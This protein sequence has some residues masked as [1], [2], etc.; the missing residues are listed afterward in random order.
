MTELNYNQLR[1]LAELTKSQ[2]DMARHQRD[3]LRKELAQLRHYCQ[4]VEAQRDRLRRE[5]DKAR[6]DMP[7]KQAM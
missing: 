4:L 6:A 7:W 5:L 2:R 3:E 1:N